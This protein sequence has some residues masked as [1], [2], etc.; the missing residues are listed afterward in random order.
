MEKFKCK[1]C[2]KC[3]SNL[4][5][6]SKEDIINIKKNSK[7]L[8][9]HRLLALRDWYMICPFLNHKNQC[10][11]YEFRPTICR[12][13]TC[14]DFEQGNISNKILEEINKGTE[15]SVTDMREKFFNN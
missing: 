2:G 14:Q 5:P 12:E 9:E 11:I 10:D 4:L 15:Y 7:E 13:F 8:Q 3:C 1:R 6:L